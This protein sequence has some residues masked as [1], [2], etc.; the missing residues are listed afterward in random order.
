[1][2]WKKCSNCGT[3]IPGWGLCPACERNE[4]LTDTIEEQ[5][6]NNRAFQAEAL[7]QQTEIEL[8]KIK[9]HARIA[10]KNREAVEH[11]AYLENNPGDY[12]CPSCKM[13]SL[14]SDASRC[15]KCQANVSSSFWSNIWESERLAREERRIA[16]E[17][18]Q[19]WLASPEYMLEQEHKKLASEAAARD[20]VKETI[21]ASL[22]EDKKNRGRDYCL[23]LLFLP[24]SICFLVYEFIKDVVDPGWRKRELDKLCPGRYEL[25][26]EVREE[27][28]LSRLARFGKEEKKGSS[29]RKQG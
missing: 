24:F 26:E 18:Q 28:G 12:Q 29:C 21:R 3:S 17:K 22:R 15:P 4:Q 1:M 19:K 16:E 14:K 6:E 9:I 10:E 5:E 27:E 2:S 23:F 7:E 20:E 11:A 25:I 13:I 8:A